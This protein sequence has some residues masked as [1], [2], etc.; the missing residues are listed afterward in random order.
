MIKTKT[1]RFQ[2]YTAIGVTFSFIALI[3]GLILWPFENQRRQTVMKKIE[4]SINAIVEQKEEAIANEI[5]LQHREAIEIIINKI[6]EIE[7]IAGIGVYDQEGN[8]FAATDALFAKH[9]SS[10][11]REAVSQSYA[12][13]EETLDHQK[14][15]AY[16]KPVIVIGEIL[17]YFKIYYTL[18]DV[19]K[20]TRLGIAIFISL[21]LTILLSLTVLLNVLL[22]RSVIGPVGVLIYA[23]RR[24]QEGHLGEQVDLRSEN[25]IGEMARTFNQ[26][27]AEN[28][29]MYRRLDEL[30]KNLEQ[31]VAQRTEEL[32][33]RNI[34]LRQEIEERERA[35]AELQRAEEKYHSLFENSAEG[36][37]QSTP[38][39]SLLIAN[40]S[41]A[42]LY[43]YDSPDEMCAAVTN[44]GKQ[45]YVNPDARK[46][47]GRLLSEKGK[48]VG[49]EARFFR[50]DR[51]VI[52]MSLTARAV[53]D[54]QGE[55][56]M[57]E[58]SIIDINK[59]KQAEQEIRSLNAALEQKVEDLRAAQD[60]LRNKNIRLNET[61]RKVEE[62]NSKIMES[63][64]YAKTI[65][66]SLLTNLDQVK[67]YLSDSFFIWM[68][69]DIVGGDIYFIDMFEEGLIIAV[70]DCTGH[71]VPGAFMTMIAFSALKR[72]IKDEACY[73]PAEIL[74]RLNLIVKTTLQQDTEYASSDDGLDASVCFIK[75]MGPDS[76]TNKYLIA[77]S[78][79]QTTDIQLIFAGARQPLLYINNG[80]LNVIKGDRQS[81]GYK[82]SDLDFSF[83]NHRV[84]IGKGMS[85]YMFTDG[86]TDQLGGK[87]RLRFGKRRFKNL[88]KENAQLPFEKQRN[89][90]LRTLDEYRGQNERQDDLTVVGFGF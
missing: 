21:L 38:D 51:S 24:L 77:N 79:Q 1:L 7:G 68:P 30:N 70:I 58:G 46:E 25:E 28:A 61:I 4:L 78:G 47:F 37:F 48:L 76:R 41:L 34:K 85:F 75:G 50:K 35:Q 52:W 15:A 83:T 43:G 14:V 10:Q 62:A 63:L 8:L 11:A 72:I 5:F 60:E 18:S 12:F 49:Y 17:G 66:Q 26:M 87:K 40:P 9:I 27:S 2:I 39:G 67:T 69:R 22:S 36:I 90:L 45:L 73:D 31:K 88:L 56:V 29:D 20:E 54:D 59:R 42:R 19:V 23:M 32:N 3:F 65:Q 13:S 55:L 44:I 6:S 89:V 33:A 53:R 57:Y 84:R 82:K 80:D 86:V 16:T 81:V 71:G 64:R 74:K